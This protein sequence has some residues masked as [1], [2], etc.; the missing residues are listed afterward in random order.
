MDI[1]ALMA[2]DGSSDFYKPDFRN[3][4]EAHLPYLKASRSSYRLSVTGSQAVVYQGDLYGL[5]NEMRIPLYC[6][7]VVMRLNDFMSPSDFDDS[8]PTLLI[9]SEQELE[10]MRQSWNASQVIN[11]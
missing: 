11:A 3:T 8:Y 1:D 10:S 6:H 9:P 5:L 4:I 7:W 2:D